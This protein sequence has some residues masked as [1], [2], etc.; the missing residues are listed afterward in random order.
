M[1]SESSLILAQLT[2]NSMPQAPGNA[3]HHQW[4]Q[5]FKNNL[6]E[7][8]WHQVQKFRVFLGNG[9]KYVPLQSLTF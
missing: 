9:E 1:W 5:Y 2:F 7:K 8:I 6:L 4:K 3:T